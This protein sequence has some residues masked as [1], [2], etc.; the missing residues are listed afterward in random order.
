MTKVKIMG[1]F[2]LFLFSY[3]SCADVFKVTLTG[4]SIS[5]KGE[6]DEEM[7]KVL[8]SFPLKEKDVFEIIKKIDKD[9]IM[10][11]EFEI[12]FDVKD[13]VL[14]IVEPVLEWGKLHLEIKIIPMLINDMIVEFNVEE[15]PKAWEEKMKKFNEKKISEEI[16]D[17]NREKT[18]EEI[19]KKAK[20]E[21]WSQERLQRV[22][23]QMEENYNL[24]KGVVGPKT[25]IKGG[26][27][28]FKLGWMDILYNNNVKKEI[29]DRELITFSDFRTIL[30]ERR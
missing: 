9:F 17:E 11:K 25:K 19:L 2:F 7:Q 20:E 29:K 26:R 3:F 23:G 16:I 24:L 8:S 22:L 13:N 21:N 30:I 28:Q 12:S 5:I 4:Y 10:R 14:T 27:M 18:K 15:Y 1:F 6:K